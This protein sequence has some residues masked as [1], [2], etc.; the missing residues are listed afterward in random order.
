MI[1]R[2]LCFLVGLLILSCTNNTKSINKEATMN[3][4][5]T[6]MDQWHHS[7][8]IADEEIFFNSLDSNAVYLGTDPSERWLKHEFEIWAMPYFQRDT[9][10]AFK[11]YNR[12]WEFS[13][14][15]KIAWF[16]E[17]LETHMGICRGSGVLVKS[18][19]N[20]K[21]KQYNLALTLANE[22][23]NEFRKI[24]NIN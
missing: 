3:E 20:W 15:S 12:V 1:N 4:L 6:F 21:I 10:W 11:P 14:D 22:K 16:D 23:M 5:N 2:F 7:A 19:D 8:A 18:K 13:E 9:A 17:L 24:Q